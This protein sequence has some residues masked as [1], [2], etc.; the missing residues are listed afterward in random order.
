MQEKFKYVGLPLFH[1]VVVNLKKTLKRFDKKL[2]RLKACFYALEIGTV[3]CSLLDKI[4][5]CIAIIK[6]GASEQN[7]FGAV[8]LVGLIGVI[9]VAVIGFFAT[10]FPLVL[11]HYGIKRFN[12]NKERH[13]WV[14]TVFMTVYFATFFKLVEAEIYWF[15]WL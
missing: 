11:I 7:M 5:T 9:P 3:I 8:Q 1:G 12:W 13:Y 15:G 4:F 14:Y 2:E 10:I 6:Y